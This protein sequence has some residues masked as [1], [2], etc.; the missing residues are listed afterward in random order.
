M[1]E[2]ESLWAKVQARQGALIFYNL[3]E[4]SNALLRE[5]I[6]VL[7]GDEARN[8]LA[9]ALYR[10]WQV[11]FSEP[12]TTRIARL[13]ECHALYAERDRSEVGKVGP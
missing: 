8:D 2:H 12:S 5:S 13:E 7:R 6:T 9:F 1:P 11:T 3:P 4:R 10:W